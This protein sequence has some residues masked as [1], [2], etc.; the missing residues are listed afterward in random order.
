LFF[1]ALALAL[2]WLHRR[3]IHQPERG[4][5]PQQAKTLMA[6]L[7]VEAVCLTLVIALS[8]WLGSVDPSG[9]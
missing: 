6:T 2:G 4:W 8:A 9:S 5:T 1:V 7:R 3:W